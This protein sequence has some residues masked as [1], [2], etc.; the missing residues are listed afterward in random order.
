M[1]K[2]VTLEVHTEKDNDAE[3]ADNERMGGGAKAGTSVAGEDMNVEGGRSE[4]AEDEEAVES[5]VEHV[6]GTLIGAGNVGN[7]T[8][9]SQDEV[10]AVT[11]STEAEESLDTEMVR[12]EALFKTLSTKRKRVKKSRIA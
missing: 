4:T 6:D 11:E 3:T 12:D 8:D 2:R 9:V 5:V 7:E 10:S 1:E